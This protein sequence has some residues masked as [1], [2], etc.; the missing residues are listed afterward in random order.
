MKDSFK[1]VYL[2]VKVLCIKSIVANMIVIG[3][4]VINMDMGY[5]TMQM[6]ISLKVSTEITKQME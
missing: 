6:V 2:M 1:M 5:F 3:L 4:M